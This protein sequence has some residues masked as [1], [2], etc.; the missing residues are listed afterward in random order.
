MTREGWDELADWR[1]H[2]MGERGDLWHRAIIDP[3]LLDVVGPVRGLRV[4][5]LACGNGYLARRWAREGAA[6][7]LGVDLSA[8]NVAH[9][10][11]REGRRPSGASFRVADAA[12]LPFLPNRSL[13][14]V[15]ANMALQ[16][17]PDAA[18][19]IREVA[20]VLR[21][22]GRFVFSGSHPCFDLD[23]RSLWVVERSR[24]DDGS[25]RDLV[26]RK[27][28]GYR[29]ERTVR[30][31]WDLPGR[32]TGYTLAYHRTLSSYV[33]MLRDAG[34]GLTRLEEPA[35]LPEAIEKS[36]QGPFLRE[37]PLHVVVE[38]FRLPQLSAA[39]RARRPGSREP[40]REAGPIRRRGRRILRR[41]A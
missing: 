32:E 29:D 5:D 20:R 38:A 13:D 26:W 7:V 22:G 3:T 17:I 37:I 30:V 14:L 35:P 1:D 24:G 10:R 6:S 15:V 12:H 11:R 16:D 8:R 41:T 4:L 25:W 28:R 2:R 40:D 36:P 34:F 31:P 33:R 19:V 21:R 18:S 9:A 27:V 23:D 39:T